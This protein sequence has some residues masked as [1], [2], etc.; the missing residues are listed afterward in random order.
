MKRSVAAITVLVYLL[1]FVQ[2]LTS[3]AQNN[4]TFF[5]SEK[6]I[7]KIKYSDSL[8]LQKA[9]NQTIDKWRKEGYI[10]AALDNIEIKNDSA[11]VNLFKGIRYVLVNYEVENN[12]KPSNT[13]KIR[14][15]KTPKVAD[16]I[17]IE[18]QQEKIV[19]HLE[20]YGYPFAQV[21]SNFRIDSN[22]LSLTHKIETCKQYRFDSIITNNIKLSNTFI[23]RYLNIKPG[24]LY[25]EEKIHKIGSKIKQL[26]FIKLEQLPVVTFSEGLARPEILIKPISSN[27]FNGLVGIVPEENSNGKY[28][29]TGD[30]QLYLLSTFN[31]G[32]AIDLQW[33][34][35]E[36]YSQQLNLQTKWPYLIKSP[37]GLEA[38]LSMLKQ[39]TSFLHVDMKIGTFILFNG[40][41]SAS[42]Y[43]TD[44]RSIVLS[45][46]D[47]LAINATNSYGSGIILLSSNL[48]NPLNPSR[49]YKLVF[50]FG[51]GNRVVSDEESQEKKILYWDGKTQMQGFIPI[52]KNW[53][54][55]AQN[56]NKIIKS[57]SDLF[58]NELFRIGGMQTLRGF[59]EN[60]F[61]TNTYNISTLEIRW[62][63]EANSH[64]KAFADYAWIESKYTNEHTKNTAGGLGVGLNLKTN[65]GI[66]TISYALGILKHEQFKLNN[67]KIHFGYINS[68]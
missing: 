16:L 32:E 56:Q 58:K 19:S 2:S 65:A 20:N 22:K 10:N 1:L 67:A 62:L 8:N 46:T 60:Q 34:K 13:L 5:V 54:I 21:K 45:T 3:F 23:Y 49:G 26:Q 68:F 39:D 41:N 24:D 27:N 52:Y 51:V 47:T 7:K 48:D 50:D 37:F 66:F 40:N 42:G 63:F 12:T 33:K 28:T 59:D 18:K 6:A 11:N 30:I 44:K 43:Y 61:Y 15:D 9:I 17:W 29:I 14:K 25:S 38:G 57:K 55:L 64:I 35:P 53:V 36:K 4:A 31:K